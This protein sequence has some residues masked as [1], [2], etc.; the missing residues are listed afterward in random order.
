VDD[1]YAKEIIVLR[2]T[3]TLEHAASAI[4]TSSALLWYLAGTEGLRIPVSALFR[5]PEHE[6][7]PLTLTIDHRTREIVVRRG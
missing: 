1:L 5:F 6:T 7:V 3:R 4:H 2:T